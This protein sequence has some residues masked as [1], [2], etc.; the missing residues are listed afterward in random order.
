MT[1]QRLTAQIQNDQLDLFRLQNQLSTGYRIFLPSDDASAA[2]RAMAIQRTLERKAQSLT[3][4]QGAATALSTADVSLNNANQSLNDLKSAALGVLDTISTDTERQAVVNQIDELLFELTRVGNSTLATNY[5]FGGAERSYEAY[6]DVN[7]YI[8]YR[9]DESSP[10]TFVDIGQLFNTGVSGDEVLGGLSEAVRG[11]ADL[12]ASLTPRTRLEQLNGGLG[13]SPDG[14]IEIRFV[15][16]STADPTT[17]SIIDLS[18]AKSI[19]DVVRLIEAGAPAGSDITVSIDGDALR[20]DSAGGG[21]TVTEVGAGS[22]AMELGLL[23]DGAPTATVNGGGLDPTLRPATRLEDLIGSKARGRIASTGDNNDLV[24]TAK[25]NGAAYNGVAVNYV[26][27]ATVGSETASYDSFTNTLTVN[28]A[29]GESTA[30]QVAAAIN[31]ESTVPFTAEADFRDQ[32]SISSRGTGA[33]NAGTGLGVGVAGGVDGQL[34]VTSGLLVT[35]GS[36]TYTIDIS[37]AET[38]EDLLGVLNNPEYGLAAAINAAGDGIDVR[39]RRSGAAFTIGEN[40]GTTATQLGI[41]SYTESSRLADFNRGVGVVEVFEDDAKTLAQN[42]FTISVTEN[43]VSTTY[44]INPLGLSTVG[45]LI[46]RISDDT[47]GAVVASLAQTGNGLVLTVTDPDS[48]ATPATGSFQLGSTP[49]TISIAAN[50]TGP[51]GNRPFTVEIVDNGGTGPISTSVTGDT[52]VVD[53]AGVTATTD[54]IAAS[55]E[56]QLPGFTVTSDGTDTISAPVAQQ[57]AATTGGAIASELAAPAS[58]SFTLLG[59]TLSIQ[60]TATGPAGNVPFSVVV[61]D[62]TS[63]GGAG[64]LQTTYDP[65]T[66]VVTVDLQGLDTTTDAIAASIQNA[67]AGVTPVPFT[68]TSNGTAAVAVT[69]VDPVALSISAATTG[70]RDADSITLSGDVAERLGFLPEGQESVTVTQSTIASTDRRPNEV[71][72]VF[73]TLIRLR[74]AL[75]ANDKEAIGREIERLDDDLDRITFA[76]GEVGTRL[77]NLEAVE[78]RLADEEVSLREAL[79]NEIDADVVDVIS[80]YTAKQ[81][82]IQ[83]SL[84]TSGALLN[85]SIL[86]YI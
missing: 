7:G 3:N 4:L 48:P 70:G 19:D 53:L 47:G 68:V 57:P 11:G 75:D 26:D 55:I 1:R 45:D 67:L 46:Q 77:K 56:L 10:Q 65:D 14:A 71:D 5:L 8:E 63:G 15:P 27:G 13:V 32:T 61:Q 54:Q 81:Y 22:T 23:H 74:E 66:N 31:A 78:Q 9:G 33:V 62:S 38:V 21:I 25:Q 20:I 69:D 12:D 52:I 18:A 37:A 83:A 43:G 30:A 58:G 50:A 79:S 17:S 36:E 80:K 24:I 60:T 42:E 59:D 51:A 44:S 41:R 6:R 73:T 76:R 2:Q 86:D 35:N 82:A 72:S 39:T 85:L 28:I 29:A 16:T 64:P 84:R 49:D 40:G 34:D